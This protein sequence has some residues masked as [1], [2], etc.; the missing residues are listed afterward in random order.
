MLFDWIQQDWATQGTA[1]IQVFVAALLG[2]VVGFERES[3]DRPAGLRTHALLAASAAL[4]TLL[5]EGL[6][7]E[8]WEDTGEDMIRADPVRMVQ[9]I[10]IGVSF[11]GAGTIFRSGSN[12]VTGLTTASALL[13]VAAIGIAVAL[14]KLLLAAAVTVMALIV[15]RVLRTVESKVNAGGQETGGETADE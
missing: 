8:L 11:I 3:V 14:G 15:L 4:L 9:A 12:H 2:G 10:V 6:V 7:F 13:L 5:T 1:V